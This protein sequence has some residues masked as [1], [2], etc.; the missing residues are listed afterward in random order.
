MMK[1]LIFVIYIQ[2]ITS[3]CENIK[4]RSLLDTLKSDSF[5]KNDLVYN[6]MCSVDRKDYVDEKNKE[7]AY[8]DRPIYIGY[9]ATISAPHMHA[10]ALEY[11]YT[12]VKDLG[13]ET[14]IKVLDIGSGSGYL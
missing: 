4:L 8:I 10:F 5:L 14:L 2:H 3:K 11:F 9:G 1:I 6:T 7:F 13:R 12:R